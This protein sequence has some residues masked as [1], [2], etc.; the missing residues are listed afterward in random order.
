MEEEV[1]REGMQLILRRIGQLERE[2][3]TRKLELRGLEQ[4]ATKNK[5]QSMKICR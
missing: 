4:I 1:L 2:I 5:R 3:W